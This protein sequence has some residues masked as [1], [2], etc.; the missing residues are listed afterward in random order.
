VGGRGW[1]VLWTS[2]G[3]GGYPSGPER[4]DYPPISR[5]LLDCGSV[6][7]LREAVPAWVQREG[8]GGMSG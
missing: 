7:V 8:G 1:W 3:R 2:G 5:D 4:G 6:G